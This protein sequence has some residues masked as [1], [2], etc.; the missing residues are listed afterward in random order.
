[1]SHRFVRYAATRLVAA[2]RRAAG[3]I[4]V[5]VDYRGGQIRIVG[6]D[7]GGGKDY[8][9]GQ[10]DPPPADMVV[11]ARGLGPDTGRWTGDWPIAWARWD[12]RAVSGS[13]DGDG[14]MG[15]ASND[16][17]GVG[18]DEWAEYSSDRAGVDPNRRTHQLPLWHGLTHSQ[19][20]DTPPW[21]GYVRKPSFATE[22]LAVRDATG[23]TFADALEAWLRNLRENIATF[24]AIDTDGFTRCE[25]CGDLLASGEATEAWG[26]SYCEDH[27][28]QSCE[29]C[30]KPVSESDACYDEGGAAYCS[31]CY[32]EEHGDILAEVT[33]VFYEEHP[34]LKRIDALQKAKNEV[35]MEP[36]AYVAIFGD[37]SWRSSFGGDAWARIAETWRD[38]RKA[39][40]REDWPEMTLLVDHAFDLVHNNGS[41]F[42]KAKDEVR[43]WLFQ[44]LEDKYFLDPLQYRDKLSPDARKVLDA[45]IRNSGGVAKWRERIE[46]A[47]DAMSR[48]EKVLLKDR[49]GKMAERLWKVNRLS[50][51]MFRDRDSFLEVAFWSK[52]RSQHAVHTGRAVRAFL[53]SPDG[54]TAVAAMVAVEPYECKAGT[55]H[56]AGATLRGEFLPKLLEVARADPVLRRLWE[57]L[58]PGAIRP[59][60][61][62]SELSNYQWGKWAEFLTGEA[63]RQ[64]E[65][66]ATVASALAAAFIRLAMRTTDF[67]DFYALNIVRCGALPD[68][69]AQMCEG[70]K[71]V[72]TLE[73]AKAL[74]KILARAVVREA[75]HV[76][77]SL[78]VK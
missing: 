24:E 32:E 29:N 47:G 5:E 17:L 42:T 72:T 64:K 39:V 13:A 55:A 69:M 52:G 25:S 62:S 67:Y 76:D 73:V 40:A 35:E 60:S 11:N 28:P 49:D 61:P 31:G 2:L 74:L 10:A 3:R 51:Q 63:R 22:A 71:K 38:L 21:S 66:S 68:D 8:K 26:N 30:G 48:F 44:A 36:E 16:D 15:F 46:A 58:V 14:M 9:R 41:L 65:D 23:A 50:P 37:L 27:R 56:P 1:M 75:R 77:D 18:W 43:S 53:R 59:D 33:D 45:Y 12:G 54:R 78:R 6:I 4:A 70:L 20:A 19:L 57:P 7:L 34:D